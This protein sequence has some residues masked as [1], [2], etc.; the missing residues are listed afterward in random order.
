MVSGC[1]PYECYLKNSFDHLVMLPGWSSPH[2]SSS[3]H[4][5]VMH[6]GPT[7]RC[8]TWDPIKFSTNVMLHLSKCVFVMKNPLLLGWKSVVFSQSC[9]HLSDSNRHTIIYSCDVFPEILHHETMNLRICIPQKKTPK[10]CLF[11]DGWTVELHIFWPNIH[12]LR[13]WPA[14]VLTATHVTRTPQHT[15]AWTFRASAEGSTDRIF[16]FRRWWFLEVS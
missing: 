15:S 9:K 4:W 8:E 6:P 1:F 5:C 2:G 13:S 7:A 10:S 16:C 14:V 11:C 12:M 3:E